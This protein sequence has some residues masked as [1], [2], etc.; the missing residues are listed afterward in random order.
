MH[1]SVFSEKLNLLGRTIEQAFDADVNALARSLLDSAGAS[2]IAVGS[3]GSAVAGEFL[4]VCRGDFDRGTTIVS[5]PMEYVLDSVRR[6]ADQVWLFSAAGNNPDILAAFEA[7][8]RHDTPAITIVTSDIRGA[9]VERAAGNRMARVH[10]A[11]VSEPKDGFL[12]THSLV[13]TLLVLLRAFDVVSRGGPEVR[14][15][16]EVCKFADRALS[17]DHRDWIKS[18]LQGASRRDMLF[19]LHD[20]LLAPAASLIETS[21]WEAGLCAVQRADFRNFA[22]GRHVGFDKNRERASIV[23]LTTNRSRRIW[24]SVEALLPPDVPITTLDFGNGG[25]QKVFE[26][27]VEGLVI[28]EALGEHRQIDPGRPGVPEFGRQIYRLQDLI[29]CVE[30]EDAAINRK[31]G[32]Q[33]RMDDPSTSSTDWQIERSKFVSKLTD[34][35]YRAVVL[36]YDGTVVE[37]D[38]RREAPSEDVLESLLR[39]LTNG[40]FVAFATG[41]GGSIGETLRPL[42]PEPYWDDVLVGYYNGGYV[43]PL[44]TNI[45]KQP[46]PAHPDLLRLDGW[47]RDHPELFREEAVHRFSN[48]QITIANSDLEDPEGLYRMLLDEGFPIGTNL[49]VRRSGHSWDICPADSG[50]T[51]VVDAVLQRLGDTGSP[52]LCVGDSGAWQG[53]D[54]DLLSGAYSLSVA[55]VCHRPSVCWNLL[56]SGLTG[57][58]GLVAILRA[59]SIERRGE[60]RFDVEQVLTAA[61]P[62]RRLEGE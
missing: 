6:R 8:A 36:D 61:A 51:R 27:V 34:A 13:A 23:A 53:N 1:M 57:P 42:V 12:A 54:Y 21:C 30:E 33:G 50:K 60:A 49:V 56:P 26:G 38:R 4:A 52:V 41:R 11:P 39:L 16:D 25:R 14:R 7:A 3:G 35:V 10:I 29:D 2:V 31:R 55:G 18:Q 45:A 22:H 37:T 44:R 32:A 19:L 47:L 48:V 46:P 40:I 20:P 9:L 15:R 59:L 5:T 58:A 62:S 28:V 24:R 17:A 43:T